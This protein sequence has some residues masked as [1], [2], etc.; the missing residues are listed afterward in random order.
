MPRNQL[1][2]YLLLKNEITRLLAQVLSGASLV[3]LYEVKSLTLLRPAA[4]RNLPGQGR[5]RK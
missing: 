3:P 2:G 1:S 4:W 5:S